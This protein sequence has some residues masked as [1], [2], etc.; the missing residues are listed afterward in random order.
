[1]TIEPAG[2]ASTDTGFATV[3]HPKLSVARLLRRNI[4]HCVEE[5]AAAQS[6]F[7]LSREPFSRPR[8]LA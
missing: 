7:S 4:F 6:D 5:S 2:S 8:Y 3:E 1:M